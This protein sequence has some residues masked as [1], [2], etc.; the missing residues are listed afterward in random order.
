MMELFQQRVVRLRSNQLINHVNGRGKEH[1]DIGVAG[2]IGQ[3]FRQEGFARTRIANENDSTVGRDEVEVAQRQDTS[4][5]CLSGFMMV[6][7]ELVNR[8][9]F[10]QS[11]LA[12]SEMDGVVPTVLQFEVSEESE[13]RNH[14]EIFLC[15]LLSGGVEL[16]EHAF[17]PE[18]GALVFEPF[19]VRHARVFWMTDRKSVV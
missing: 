4:F 3:A 5:L 9:F 7:V 19:G 10:C 1:L 2:R 12:P 15:G 14:M 11:G 6:E 8:Q 18:I 13:G 16:R 17:E